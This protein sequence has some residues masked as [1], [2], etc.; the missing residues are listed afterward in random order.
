MNPQTGLRVTAA[1][2]A[3]QRET[4]Q[5]AQWP[6]ELQPWLANTVLEQIRLPV[7]DASCPSGSEYQGGAQLAMRHLDDS[8]RLF[9]PKARAGQPATGVTVDLRAEGGVGQHVWLVNGALAGVDA[10]QHGLRYTFTRA[11]DYD[12]TVFDTAGSVDK[13]VIRVISPP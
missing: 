4:C 5:V 2:T 13:V 9:L 10:T 7:F 11:G 6:L 12:L 8:T 3:P 1:C